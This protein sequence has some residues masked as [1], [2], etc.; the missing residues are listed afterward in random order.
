[1]RLIIKNFYFIYVL[2]SGAVS[3]LRPDLLD[4]ER[5][6]R[7]ELLIE[8]YDLATPINERRSVRF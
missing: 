4:Y 7:F 5:Q 3:I 8:V 2:Q 1:M 6:Q